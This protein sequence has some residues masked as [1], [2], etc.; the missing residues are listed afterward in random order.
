LEDAA[1]RRAFQVPY[2]FRQAERSRQTEQEVDVV[3]QAFAFDQ[4]DVVLPCDP[5]KR[6]KQAG[7]DVAL[8]SVGTSLW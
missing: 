6:L 4:E 5:V 8:K 2:R 3:G 7:P 1:G